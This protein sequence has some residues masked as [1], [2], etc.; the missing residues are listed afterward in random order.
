M[1]EVEWTPV[2]LTAPTNAG[3]VAAADLK[4]VTQIIILAAKYRFSTARE[5]AD[6]RKELHSLALRRGEATINALAGLS[7]LLACLRELSETAIPEKILHHL[8]DKIQ[9]AYDA[10]SVQSV[11]AKRKADGDEGVSAKQAKTLEGGAHAVGVDEDT[12]A[13]TARTAAPPT[14]AD[15]ATIMAPNPA[16]YEPERMCIC[17]A[18]N[19]TEHLVQ[20]LGCD[21]WFHPKC[22]RRSHYKDTTWHSKPLWAFE[23]DVLYY[24]RNPFSC[25]NCS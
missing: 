7:D 4:L 19:N 8:A 5:E 9:E 11:A 1:Y 6:G 2:A 22:V 17:F 10:R 15:V 23:K 20:C 14:T 12:K 3:V 18:A 13:A 24:S 21:K 25:W 16:S